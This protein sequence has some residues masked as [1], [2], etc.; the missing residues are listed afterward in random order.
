MLLSSL[1]EAPISTIDAFLL[2]LISPNIDLVSI[3]PSKEQISEV[4]SPLL[5]QET[6]HSA[7]RIRSNI[8]AIEA[9]VRT[10]VSRFIESRNRLAIL[11]GGQ[12]RAEV[13]LTGMLTKSLFVEESKIAMKKRSRQK[14]TAWF[15]SKPLDTE[16]L[17]DMFLEPAVDIID[18]FADDL[19]AKL[20]SWVDVILTQY[21]ALVLN[22]ENE[23]ATSSTRFNHL[24]DLARNSYPGE[25]KGK[26]QWV[27][28]VALASS[29]Y[30]ALLKNK[31]IFFPKGIL[32]QQNHCNGWMPGLFSK[33]KVRGIS[34]QLRRPSLKKCRE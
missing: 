9:G 5:I 16:I 31:M 19:H 3:N 28:L 15:Q 23:Q 10:D 4:R 21:S 29:T 33:S 20:N 25:A 32:P 1:D 18:G 27:W 8:D 24:V 12:A 6:I 2:Q 13:I 34:V 14:G 22:C 30:S 7:W 26:L 11:A 17:L